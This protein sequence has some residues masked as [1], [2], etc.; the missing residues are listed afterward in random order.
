MKNY[1]IPL[2]IIESLACARPVVTTNISEFKLW[3]RKAIFYYGS[4]RE[5]YELLDNLIK[6]FDTIQWQL[7]SYS[8]VIRSQYSWENIAEAYRRVI[9]GEHHAVS[10]DW[11]K[12]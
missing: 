5:I 11:H 12:T 4:S 6:E 8:E 7:V 3:F 9:E 2:K 1:T 10:G